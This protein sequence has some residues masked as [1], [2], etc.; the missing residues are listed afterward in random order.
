MISRFFY[1]VVFS[2]ARGTGATFSPQRSAGSK[3]TASTTKPESHKSYFYRGARPLCGVWAP[4]DHGLNQDSKKPESH[5]SYFY[6]GAR[7]L[8]GVWAPW[9][10]GLNQEA[11]VSQILLLPGCAPTLWCLAPWAQG[12]NKEAQVSQILLLQGCAPTFWCLRSLGAE[13]M[14]WS[15]KSSG[16]R[17]Y[18]LSAQI[19]F[20]RPNQRF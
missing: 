16:A 5:K 11:R 15:P 19:L 7:P 12:L 17:I 9:G 6:R 14:I 20:R 1:K 10:Q 4:W 8:C 18:D 3:S 2:A 13:S